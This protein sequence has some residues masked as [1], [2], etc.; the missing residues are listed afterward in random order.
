MVSMEHKIVKQIPLYVIKYVKKTLF[1]FDIVTISHLGIVIKIFNITFKNRVI[2]IFI[3]RHFSNEWFYFFKDNRL[4]LM[5]NNG[6]SHYHCDNP[7][8]RAELIGI[9]QRAG[10]AIASGA[11]IESILSAPSRASRTIQYGKWKLSLVDSDSLLVLNQYR[12]LIIKEDSVH[13]YGS[14]ND[15]LTLWQRP[16]EPWSDE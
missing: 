14:G 8:N 10:A 6:H 12:Q 2:K 16:A 11:Q 3:S 7:A 15:P 9:L 1:F 13:L 5:R 4:G